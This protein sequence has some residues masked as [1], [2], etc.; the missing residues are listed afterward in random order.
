ME[1][2]KARDQ[3][4]ASRKNPL[5]GT[6]SSSHTSNSS[7]STTTSNVSIQ[8]RTTASSSLRSSFIQS[9]VKKSAKTI[10]DA[11]VDYSYHLSSLLNINFISYSYYFI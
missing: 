9:E 5:L 8:N 2:R 4:L 3:S 6:I 1:E 10:S 7:S 11:K